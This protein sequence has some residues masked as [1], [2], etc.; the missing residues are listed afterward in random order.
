MNSVIIDF[1]S[2]F[3][4]AFEFR[5]GFGFLWPQDLAF[6]FELDLDS[7][8]GATEVVNKLSSCLQDIFS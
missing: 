5:E 7:G 1:D 6:A 8:I 3:V 4:L 2:D